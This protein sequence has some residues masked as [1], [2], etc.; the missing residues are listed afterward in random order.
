MLRGATRSRSRGVDSKNPPMTDTRPLRHALGGFATGVCVVT[1][2]GARGAMGITVNSFTSVSLEP[3]TVLW[4]LGQKS[5]RWPTFSQA[6]HFAV[7]VLNSDGAELC[8]RF[9]F[10]NPILEPDEFEP[11][12]GG[13]PLI[14]GW[15][16]RF[17][18]H[19]CRRE[20]AGDHLLIFG[21]VER[22]EARNGTGLAF[23]RGSYGPISRGER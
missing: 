1:A 2:M 13:V 9:A 4:S 11:G 18:C 17:E 21:R 16:S 22:F 15:I 10:G 7:H 6:D 12:I 3:P 23:F 20:D 19:V 5:D 8:Q 14:E